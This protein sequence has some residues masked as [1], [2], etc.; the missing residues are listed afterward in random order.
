VSVCQGNRGDTPRTVTTKV[1]TDTAVQVVARTARCVPPHLS[2]RRVRPPALGRRTP[3][4]QRD[5]SRQRRYHHR[6][7]PSVRQPD[8][9]MPAGCSSAR[10]WSVSKSVEPSPK[11]G[12]Q[13]HAGQRR[14]ATV[15]PERGHPRRG[16]PRCCRSKRIYALIVVEHRS[17][18][19]HLAGITPNPT[20]CRSKSRR[21]S[22]DTL[23]RAPSVSWSVDH[24]IAGCLSGPRG[25]RVRGYSEDMDTWGPDFHHK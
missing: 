22:S 25:G 5:R 16:W 12:A 11:T 14:T 18:R 21:R 17:R 23:R 20:V 9:G 4:G 8:G 7:G 1:Y 6:K 15:S 13:Q 3:S 24:E 10:K 19:V 2:G